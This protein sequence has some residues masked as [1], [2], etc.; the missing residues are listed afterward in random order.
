MNQLSKEVRM[1]YDFCEQKKNAM[2]KNAE[3]CDDFTTSMMCTNQSTVYW[4]IQQFIDVN[5][6]E[7]TNE[8]EER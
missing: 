7:K 8:K 5:F 2:D 4:A 1:I 3:M 6:R